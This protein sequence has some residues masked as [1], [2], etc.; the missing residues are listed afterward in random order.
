MGW[1]IIMRIEWHQ[2]EEKPT[3]GKQQILALVEEGTFQSYDIVSW[4]NDKELEANNDSFDDM[5]VVADDDE[6][7][8]WFRAGW[9]HVNDE[10]EKAYPRDVIKWS[11]LP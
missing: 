4:Y 6:C 5:Y 1:Y 10:E 11:Y 8:Y 7:C 2:P 9:Y 3:K